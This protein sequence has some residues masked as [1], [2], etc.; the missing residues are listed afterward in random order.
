[1]IEEK[2]EEKK[3]QLDKVRRA[4]RNPN[5]RGWIPRYL[6]TI[7]EQGDTIE[8]ILPKMEQVMQKYC[9]P[10][11]FATDEQRSLDEGSE[12]QNDWRSLLVELSPAV[13]NFWANRYDNY[14][15]PNGRYQSL[16]GFADMREKYMGI[17][18]INSVQ[19]LY[20]MGWRPMDTMCAYLLSMTTNRMYSLSPDVVREAVRLDHEAAAHL[21][22][23]K[24]LGEAIVH[25]HFSYQT[26][27]QRLWMEFLYLFCGFE[28][29]TFLHME[30]ETKKLKQQCQVICERLSEP[31]YEKLELEKALRACALL[32]SK[33]EMTGTPDKKIEKKQ[34]AALLNAFVSNYQWSYPDWKAIR[35]PKTNRE[36]SDTGG[37]CLTDTQGC[38]HGLLAA[39][40][41]D[42]Q[43][44]R[45][46]RENLLWGYYENGK[47]QIAFALEEDGQ[48]ADEN[49]EAV[50]D[51]IFSGQGRIG[52][53]HPEELTATERDIWKKYAGKKKW[54][55]PF[56]QLKIPVCQ[57]QYDLEVF[58]G[59]Q[60]T[61]LFMI[62][63]AGKWGLYQ[64]SDRNQYMSYH[65]ADLLHGYGAQLTFDGIWRG[66]EYGPEIITI[67]KVIF[68]RFRHFLLWDHVP[69]SLVCAPEELPA[70]FVSTAMAAFQGIIGKGK[71]KE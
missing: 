44:S 25:H 36:V 20:G 64:G 47:L 17:S 16:L 12:K 68:Y 71:K 31:D 26:E 29:Q 53:V 21:L 55:Q 7:L 63:A 62:T 11:K 34:K 46:M 22:D 61:Q 51:I 45:T 70:R 28:D 60:V 42:Y 48:I 41:K 33:K 54:K 18:H 67:D 9:E 8:D 40:T 39:E 2:M 19:V 5:L 66:P 65:M 57:G 14:I 15:N 69:E 24:A 43:T 6:L 56:P 58:N 10:G 49:E 32:P 30:H 52:L 3:V 50:S 23:K 37:S 59:M 27:W 4:F 1:M 38:L 35:Y 13:R